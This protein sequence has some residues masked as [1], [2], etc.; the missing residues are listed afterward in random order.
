MIFKDLSPLIKSPTEIQ[1]LKKDDVQPLFTESPYAKA[2]KEMIE[3]FDSRK[4][5]PGIVFLG[6]D[7]S[8][9]DSYSYRNYTGAPHFAVDV[10]PKDP[11]EQAAN[12]LIQ[13]LDKQGLSFVQG[14]RAM[15]F[16][17]DTG[18]YPNARSVEEA[19]KRS[20]RICAGAPL[21]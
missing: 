8:V 16:P 7:E 20:G 12:D 13:K 6:L 9:K 11:Y 21:P 14:M 10:T 3:N 18:K 1:Y 5:L 2:E 15:S 17:P 4:A 19:D